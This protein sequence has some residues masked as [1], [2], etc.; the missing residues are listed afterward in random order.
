MTMWSCTAHRSL[1]DSVECGLCWAWP[2]TGIHFLN[3][4]GPEVQVTAQSPCHSKTDVAML[5]ISAVSLASRGRITTPVM[6]MG[7]LSSLQCELCVTSKCYREFAPLSAAT[8]IT[9]I[10]FCSKLLRQ[11]S[12]LHP[13]IQKRKWATEHWLCWTVFILCCSK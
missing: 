8:S 11:D 2:G 3:P 13:H 4:L 6:Q 10:T 1:L 7:R 12:C 9:G 5:H